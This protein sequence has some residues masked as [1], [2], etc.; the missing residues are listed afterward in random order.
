MLNAAALFSSAS[1]SHEM[2]VATGAP[3]RARND[4]G[5]V[6]VANFCCAANPRKC[7]LFDA[8]RSWLRQTV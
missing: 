6:A 4:Q 7:G 8:V 2:G 5:R 1:S 3:G